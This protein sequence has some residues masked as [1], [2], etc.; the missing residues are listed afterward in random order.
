MFQK[1]FKAHVI[2]WSDMTRN[3]TIKEWSKIGEAG[4]FF[5]NDQ[6]CKLND[7]GNGHVLWSWK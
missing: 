1:N 4:Q 6:W 3:F 7:N 2:D 5:V